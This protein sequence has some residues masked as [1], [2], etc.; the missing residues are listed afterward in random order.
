MVA[1]RD[2]PAYS[3]HQVSPTTTNSMSPATGE[4]EQS[5]ECKQGLA[6]CMLLLCIIRKTKVVFNNEDRRRASLRCRRKTLPL[7]TAHLRF[8]ISLALAA[9]MPTRGFLHHQCRCSS[10]THSNTSGS[11][12]I[13]ARATS[14]KTVTK[15]I[16]ALLHTGD[17]EYK[18]YVGFFLQPEV[19]CS[20][21][22]ANYLRL[23]SSR[24]IR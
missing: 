4:T 6:S 17:T 24:P 15:L 9:N 11:H 10:P 22:A 19:R 20:T 3:Q 7:A 8:A 18:G 13:R 23:F 1:G 2:W 5:Q 14:R 16:W 21:A 12:G